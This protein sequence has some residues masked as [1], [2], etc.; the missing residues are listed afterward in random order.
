MQRPNDGRG[1]ALGHD[2]REDRVVLE[3]VWA[4][5][6]VRR[7]VRIHAARGEVS[8]TELM[9][10]FAEE[11]RYAGLEEAALEFVEH[12]E[13]EGLVRLLQTLPTLADQGAY[14]EARQLI[15]IA[16]PP[17]AAAGVA[18][19]VHAALR[20]VAAKAIEQ[21]GLTA[22][23]PF[24]EVIVESLRQGP[25]R[26]LPDPEAVIRAAEQAGVHDLIVHLR[27]GYETTIGEGAA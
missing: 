3:A 5:A 6:G 13:H 17:I 22:G 10:R 21:H 14:R 7:D 12:A 11:A 20:T 18:G 16:F 4:G 8:L 27:N 1:A 15:D 19:E 9:P 26:G 2:A 23:E 24:R 25:G